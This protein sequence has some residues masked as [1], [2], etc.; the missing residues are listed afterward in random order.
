MVSW[1]GGTKNARGIPKKRFGGGGN[2]PTHYYESKGGWLKEM[3]GGGRRFVLRRL[4]KELLQTGMK[5]TN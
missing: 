2:I 3:G 5:G 4:G 1:T